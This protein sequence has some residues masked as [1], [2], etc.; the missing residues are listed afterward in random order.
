MPRI[1]RPTIQANVGAEPSLLDQPLRRIVALLA[2]RLKRPKP[3]L[4]DVAMVRLN[5]IA[6]GRWGDEAALEAELAQ[7][8][9]KKLVP[10]YTGPASR[11]V[12]G[13]PLRT[14]TTNTHGPAS[15]VAA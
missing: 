12:P 7:G 1:E 3:E 15:L 2:E 14:L 5:V 4:V 8:V 6:D 13:V 9:L 11:A 10:A